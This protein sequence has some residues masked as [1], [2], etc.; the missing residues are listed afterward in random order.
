MT[1]LW[2]KLD[3]AAP[4]M[5]FGGVTVDQ[6][7][8]TRDFPSASMLTGLMAN[9][10]GLDWTDR[11]AHQD[12]QD[13]LI[14]GAALLREGVRLTDTQ[15]VQLA[16]DDRG[17]TTRGVPEG[18]DGASY[19]AP[20]RRWRD[21]LADARALVVLRLA[22]GRPDTAALAAA[23]ERPARP[24]FIGRKPC[25]P[26][27][28]LLAG[29]VTAATA[30]EAL[31]AAGAAGARALW[32]AAEGPEGHHAYPITD[33]RNWGTTLLHGGRRMV[34]EGRLPCPG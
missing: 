4:L 27:A 3:L 1:Y 23:L 11:A 20:H 30:W 26:S 18:R 22:P 19:N 5:A 8:V 28:P 10:L 6:I 17:W 33:Q 7:G 32:P 31:L 25:L 13:R 29:R 21:H 14:F 34:V 2:L 16:K 24:L 12:L 9:A 15:N